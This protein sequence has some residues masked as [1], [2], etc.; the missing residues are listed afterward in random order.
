M[1]PKFYHIA[2]YLDWHRAFSLNDF[3]LKSGK[4]TEYKNRKFVFKY[5]LF[6]NFEYI[7]HN[8]AFSIYEIDP[9]V[10][11]WVCRCKSKFMDCFQHQKKNDNFVKLF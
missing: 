1:P 10:V 4:T 5:G 3:S 11:G 7:N 2:T 9:W 8:L 6:L